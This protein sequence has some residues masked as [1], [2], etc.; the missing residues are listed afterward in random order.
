MPPYQ[1]PAMDPAA[2]PM[3]TARSSRA[4]RS[5]TAGKGGVEKRNQNHDKAP[6][7]DA[8]RRPASVAVRRERWIPWLMFVFFVDMLLT[9][10]PKRKLRLAPTSPPSNKHITAMIVLRIVGIW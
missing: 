3:N 9:S 7:P 6:T 10:P 8:T 1:S 2:P 5:R 4:T